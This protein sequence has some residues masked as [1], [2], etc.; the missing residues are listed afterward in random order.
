MK[1]VA[2]KRERLPEAIRNNWEVRDWTERDAYGTSIQGV[3]VYRKGELIAEGPIDGKPYR[4]AR[5]NIPVGLISDDMRSK[6]GRKP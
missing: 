5:R 2:K 1:K 4:R 3:S 6:L